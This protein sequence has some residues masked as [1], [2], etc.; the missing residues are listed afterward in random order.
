M[1]QSIPR[2]LLLVVVND[3]DFSQQIVSDSITGL[4]AGTYNL[5]IQDANNC[6]QSISHEI[7][8]PIGV[9]QF[10]SY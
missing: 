5:S 2:R 4:S 6:I 3:P 10:K 7:F 8:G 9:V 1:G